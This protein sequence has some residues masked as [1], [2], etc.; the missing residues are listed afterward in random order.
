MY[1]ISPRLLPGVVSAFFAAWIGLSAAALAADEE[2]R[3]LYMSTCSKCH[4]GIAEDAISRRNAELL[5]YVVTMPLG[6]RLTGVFGR[7]AGIIENYPYSRGFR[8]MIENPWV[9]DEES[10]DLWLISSQAFIRG[11]TMFLKVPDPDERA[12]IIGYLKKYAQY[13]G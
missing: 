2:A 12:K 4:G 13:K 1:H 6:P 7:E 3:A 11:S 9:W 8:A 5:H 10:L